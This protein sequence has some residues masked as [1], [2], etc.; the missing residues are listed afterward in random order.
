LWICWGYMKRE[1]YTL[2]DEELGYFVNNLH[3]QMEKEHI[4]YVLVGG[5]AVQTHVLKRL[6]Y[7]TGKN[8]SEL[9]LTNEI[10]LQ[11]YLRGTDDVD[12]AISSYVL[13][14]EGDINFAK[15]V[16]K[17]LDRLDVKE[18]ISPSEEFLLGYKLIRRGIKRPCF[19]VYVDEDR[20]D[21]MQIAMNIGRNKKD[22]QNLDFENYDV[23]V[24]GGQLIQLPFNEYFSINTRV[25][26]PEHL[27]VS[28]IA[29]FRAKDTMDLHSLSDLMRDCKEDLDLFQIKKFLLP[30]Y[31]RNYRRFL[32]LVN[33]SD[34]SY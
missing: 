30:N 7:K 14:K 18:V 8:L 12:L 27:I 16:N 13:E 15:K 22:L 32:E 21:E 11:D 23:F 28:K 9:V 20:D 17:V 5:T 31:E 25:I 6:I 33:L 2:A 10:R 1:L 26:K 24:D 4:P 34:D 19:Q 3:E 29:K